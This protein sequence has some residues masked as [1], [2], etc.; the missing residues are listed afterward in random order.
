M[1]CSQNIITANKLHAIINVYF[2]ANHVFLYAV[3]PG[4]PALTAAEITVILT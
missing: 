4:G 1:I 3:M 2:Y